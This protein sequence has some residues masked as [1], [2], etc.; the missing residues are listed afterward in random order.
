MREPKTPLP[1]A[2]EIKGPINESLNNNG[3]RV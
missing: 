3:A 1:E 2:V